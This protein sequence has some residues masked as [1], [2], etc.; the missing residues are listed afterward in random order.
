[1]Y[2]LAN[3]LIKVN[4]DARQQPI[5]EDNQTAATMLADLV[6][7]NDRYSTDRFENDNVRATIDVSVDLLQRLYAGLY[8]LQHTIMSNYIGENERQT[9]GEELIRAKLIEPLAG[10]FPDMVDFDFRLSIKDNS[11][12]IEGKN[13]FTSTILNAIQTSLTSPVDFKREIAFVDEDFD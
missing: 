2:K 4:A 12:V 1:M 3:N 11:M 9:L 8:I 13:V 6:E 7:G 10:K 5:S